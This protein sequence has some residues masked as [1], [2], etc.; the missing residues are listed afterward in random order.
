MTTESKCPFHH[1]STPV[2]ASGSGT[3]NRDWWPNQLNLKILHQHTSLSDPLDKG[4]N[5]AEAFNSLDLDAIKKDLHAL[6]TDSQAWWP[7]DFGHYGPLFVRMAWHSAGT[8]RTGDGRGGAGAGQQRFAPLN[9]WPD[10]VNLDKARRLLWP[11]KQKYGQKISWADLM[12]LTGNVALESMGFKTFGFAGGRADVWEPEEDAYWGSETTWLG[13]DKRY[14]G[15][16]SLENP[17]AAVQMGLIYVNPEGPNGN[18]DPLAAA[19]DIRETF[20]RMA[21][22]DE[23]TVALIAGGHTFG[24]THGAG[25]A[26]LVGPEPEA[27][28]IEEQGLGWTS[29]FGSGKGGDTISSGLEVTWTQT[30]TQ[31]SNYFFQNLFG[32]EWELTKSPAGAH[33][34][35]PKGGA[36]AGEVPD[37]HDPSKRHVPTML[38][39][40]LSLRF[41]PAYEKISRRFYQNPDQFADAFARA[42]FKLTHR[43]MGP[44][45]RYLGPDIP[46]EALLWQDP[47]PAVNHTLV[48]EQDIADLKAKVLASGLTVSQLVST[49]WASASTFR[50]SDKR[51]GANGARIRLAP[52]K[53]WAVNQPDSLAKVLSTLEAI[54]REFNRA[55]SDNKQVSLADLIVLAGAVG[56]EQAAKTAGHAVTVPFTPG[57]MDASQEQTDVESFAVLEPIADGFRNYLKGRY[58][59]AA[60]ALLVDKAQ[61]LTLSA[62]EMTVLVGGL[63]VLGANVGQASH[64]VFTTQPGALTNDFFV[65]LLDM[66]T[67]WKAAAGEEGVFEGRDRVSGDLKWTGTRVDLIFGSHSQLRALAEVYGSTD[68]QAKFVHDFVAAWTKVMNLDRFDLA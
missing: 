47:I 45:A 18:P 21:M 38:T 3:D 33:Q 6:M 61:L 65:N 29:K 66:G 68:A 13:G 46:A 53:D 17:L 27:A 5:Y 62:P 10:N 41:D 42:W 57:R 49:A 67:T 8:Y 4:F 24:K 36:G 32:Y 9:S 59:V 15:E 64:G 63:R 25:D 30:P 1:Q 44:R 34:W 7:A 60:E 56:V 35:Q 52:Q 19:K 31:W 54:Q 11:I 50:G 23:E 14:S 12:I 26:A 58:S 2:T 43:D 51:G 55:Q 48:S 20:S 22:N 28:G 39:T 16:R 40:D 37:A